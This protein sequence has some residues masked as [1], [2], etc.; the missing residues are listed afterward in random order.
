MADETWEELQKRASK[1]AMDDYVASSCK[2]LRMTKE[3]VES[4]L[5]EARVDKAKLAELMK[6]VKSTSKTNS[7][8]ASAIRK[9]AGL[10]EVAV[11]LLRKLT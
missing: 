4:V 1:T 8:K 7:A 5:K 2:L 10:A 9:V 3:E 6:T 11:E